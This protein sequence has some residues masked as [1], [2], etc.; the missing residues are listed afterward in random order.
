[1]RL[2]ARWRVVIVT[3]VLAVVAGA[4][5]APAS[6]AAPSATEALSRPAATTPARVNQP[7]GSAKRVL[8]FSVPT[9]AW[10]DLRHQRLPHL[11]RLLAGAAVAD[12]SVRT[13]TRRTT[14]TDGYATLNA[15]TRTRGSAAAQLAF[16]ATPA[17]QAHDDGDPSDPPHQLFEAEPPNDDPAL[18][19]FSDPDSPEPPATTPA[20]PE[21]DGGTDY[22]A[23]AI[24]REFARR[25]GV[26]PRAGEVFNFG[27]VPM[28]QS[29][30]ALYFDTEVGAMGTTLSRAGIARAVIANGDHPEGPDIVAYRREASLGLMDDRGIVP[31]GRV[32]HA[33]LRR[34]ATAPFGVRYDID[35]VLDAFDTFW[36]DRSVVLVEGSDLV[37]Y[38]DFKGVA[39]D[40]QRK[41]LSTN[42]L[43][44]TD[45][46]FGR[47]LERV[48]LHRD[49]VVVVA[50][51]AHDSGNSLTVLGIRAPQLRAGLLSSGTTRRAGFVQSVDIAPSIL[52]LMGVAPP[53]S[54]EG[55]Q[56]E[57][58]GSGGSYA[59]RVA[60]LDD[61]N[62]AAQF[63]DDIIG[64]VS[65]FFVIAQLVL[66]LLAV[67]AI[68]RRSTA[69]LRY[70]L[71]VLALALLVFLPVTFIAGAFPFFRWGDGAYWAFVS[72]VP[73]VV[74]TLIHAI[75]R[76]NFVDPVLVALL[77]IVGFISVDV[78]TGA[79]LQFNTVFGYTPTVAGRFAGIGNPAFS[80]LT[81][82]GLLLAGLL[83][84]RISGRRGTYVA[85]GVLVWMV[86]ID[87]LPFW[88]SDVGGAL[89]L[90]TTAAVVSLLLLDVKVRFRTVALWLGGA[91]VVTIAFGFLDLTRPPERRSH[92]GRLLA[93]IGANGPEAL[94]SV[95]IR[96]LIANLSVILGSIWTLMVPVA[97][98]FL[99]YVL[100]R[101]PGRIRRIAETIPQERPVVIGLIV[102]MLLGFGLNDSGISVPGLMLGVTNA[103]L[104]FLLV[105]VSDPGVAPGRV[106]DVEDQDPSAGASQSRRTQIPAGAAQEVV[107]T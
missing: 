81:A 12:L 23:S 79:S 98:V 18:G 106:R 31:A 4:L 71:E 30:A 40:A 96:K 26:E 39:S 90:V 63:R 10:S 9:L 56:I 41:R 53:S 35:A 50:P 89:T 94:R 78:V 84:F 99:A 105:R 51:W 20:E 85:I 70:S 33:L 97:F 11:E 34:D 38:E 3:L 55:T 60:L 32:G 52:S 36:A 95:I 49:A 14:P 80:V 88:G 61:A 102:A 93:D 87:G 77:G 8:V 45:R 91:V 43:E 46:L 21:G 44:A 86:L 1:M 104:V 25:T 67:L 2:H 62:H 6:G 64:P 83:A 27:L 66:W 28:L 92:L 29:N 58:E 54:M 22:H 42:A 69:R 5:F 65:T 82:A 100:W 76:A 57:R 15:G 68:S 59:E 13:V 17:R 107:S 72:V 75:A 16:V 73:L 47:L 101:A 7:L 24:T 19:V 74:A 37:R 48:D 103:T